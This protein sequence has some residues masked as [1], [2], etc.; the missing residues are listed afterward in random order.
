M[1]PRFGILATLE[2]CSI[3]LL[4]YADNNGGN[5]PAGKAT[6]EASLSLIHPTCEHGYAYLLCGK[7]GSESVAQEILNQGKRLGPDTCGW[8]Y[9]EDLRS[10]D[11]PRLAQFWDKE[12]L[13]HNGQRLSDGG[14][15]VMF[16]SGISEYIPATQWDEFLAEQKELFAQRKNW[17]KKDRAQ[18]P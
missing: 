8:N 16:V 15:I 1:L 18:E 3:A 13:G 11:D 2:R 14:H 12:G 17:Q 4:D 10:D 9:V 7:T 6:P 5:F